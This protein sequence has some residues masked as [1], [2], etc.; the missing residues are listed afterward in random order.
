MKIILIATIWA[1]AL[2]CAPLLVHT[3]LI[4]APRLAGITPVLTVLAAMHLA[5]LA[6]QRRCTLSRRRGQG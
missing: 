2:I 4:T 5:S 6:P 1:T 3:G